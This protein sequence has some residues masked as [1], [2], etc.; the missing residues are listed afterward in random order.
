MNR[1]VNE[2]KFDRKDGWKNVEM[3][4]LNLFISN[5]ESKLCSK[6]T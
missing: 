5:K 3:K 6:F 2:W 4:E 1:L